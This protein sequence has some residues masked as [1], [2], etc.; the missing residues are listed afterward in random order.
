M[1]L[2]F[3]HEN[4]DFDALA[5]QLAAYKL[6]PDARPVLSS[7][8]NA[9]VARFLAAYSVDLPFITRADARSGK[10]ARVT[11]VDTARQ[12]PFKGV[13][14]KTLTHIIDHHALD[15]ALALNETFTGETLG[16][17]TT[18]LIEKIEA[19]ASHASPPAPPISLTPIEATLLALGI[20][21]DTGSLTYRT[22]T[23][24]D[25]RAVAWLLER[26]ASLDIVR[27]YLDPPL[28]EDQE[29]IYAA[30]LAAAETRQMAGYTMVVAAATAKRYIDQLN[31]VVHR[32]RDTLHPHA[33]IALVS[34]PRAEDTI[35]HIVCRSN[36]DA[37]DVSQIA[38]LYGG[39][40][41]GRAAAARVINRAAP[42]VIAEIW[43]RVEQIV[44]PAA[45]AHTISTWDAPSSPLTPALRMLIA[46]I[47]TY[48]ESARVRLY[49]VGGIV[50][51]LQLQRSTLDVDFMIAPTPSLPAPFAVG[52]AGITFAH[53]LAAAFGGTVQAYPAFGTAKWR[54]DPARL[55]LPADQLPDHLDFAAAR[56]ET[57]AE[58]TALPS[59]FAGTLQQDLGR[60][61]FT[62]NTL[63]IQ[64]TPQMEAARLI[65][66]FDGRADLH[67]KLIR[68]LH[69]QSFIDD[70][71][72]TIR[73]IRFESRL[74]FAIESQT[75]ALMDAA[76]PYLARIT[77][78]RLRNEITLILRE[79]QPEIAL[80]R[81]ADRGYLTAIHPAFRISDTAALAR[82]LI[83]LRTTPAPFQIVAPPDPAE[84]AWH[85]ISIFLPDEGRAAVWERLLFGATKTESL[86]AAAQIVHHAA[87]LADPA[88]RVSAIAAQLQDAPDLALWA[89]WIAFGDAALTPASVLTR[90]RLQRYADEWRHIRP[91]T[92]GDA[93]R[94]MGLQPGRCYGIIL[95]RLRNARLDGEITSESDERRQIARWVDE[96][97]CK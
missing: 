25:A 54:L 47:V 36:D 70:P 67:A 60:R 85:V 52:D 48:A 51:D 17:T 26:G 71:T 3:T 4:A 45:S 39:G 53:G 75:A 91:I 56:G 76:R 65:D 33:V 74:G 97:L 34:M 62:I 84:L 87:L 27:T 83:A 94:K 88:A 44:H 73:A 29:A 43:A 82:A 66:L 50:R 79:D 38:A 11:L 93:L 37:I 77:G 5:A 28:N 69:T 46:R 19:Q 21:E 9:N 2:I 49:M 24:R 18:L 55:E 7:R 15:R 42:A 6:Y 57:Y 61:D 20:Y 96:G 35:T 13:T 32:L 12:M 89:A 59:V 14:S 10:V 8:L 90:A 58:P 81:L 86:N 64:L 63:A 80:A 31:S 40:G 30:L 92:T 23:P 16:A 22:T 72:R 78:E 1:H 95:E 41:H 68:A